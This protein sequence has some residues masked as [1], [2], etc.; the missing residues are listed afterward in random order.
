MKPSAAFAL[1]LLSASLALAQGPQRPERVAPP[2]WVQSKIAE[3]ERLPPASPPRSI[4]VTKHEGKTVYFV[5]AACCDIPSELYDE[6]GTLLC[7]PNGS[8]SGGDGRCPSFIP[9][10]T[11]STTV[12][13]DERGASTAASRPSAPSGR[14]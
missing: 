5:S 2:P 13:R 8:F 9:G 7:Y 1:S 11:P 3:Y 4:V 14:R 6:K 12:W 10:R